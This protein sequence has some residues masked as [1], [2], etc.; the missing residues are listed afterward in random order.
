VRCKL[1]TRVDGHVLVPGYTDCVGRG[2]K[3]AVAKE[4]H[5]K[6]VALAQAALGAEARRQPHRC[7]I[8]TGQNAFQSV[9]VNARSPLPIDH[10]HQFPRILSKFNFELAVLVD[11]KLAFWI[12]DASAFGLVGVVEI[13]S[14][15]SRRSLFCCQW[16]DLADVAGG[17]G[18]QLIC[19]C[20]VP[21][22]VHGVT[23][24]DLL[25]FVGPRE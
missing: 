11:G 23:Q 17:K 2:Y 5:S 18:L 25:N 20:C 4:I 16:A 10:I 14:G 9:S 1:V 8:A 15:C 19:L 12:Q 13:G 21:I 3:A 24:R 7:T 22:S 6:D